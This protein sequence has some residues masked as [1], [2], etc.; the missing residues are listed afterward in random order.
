LN[1]LVEWSGDG[2]VL[3]FPGGIYYT[4]E[5]TGVSRDVRTDPGKPLVGAILRRLGSG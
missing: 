2:I 3:I 4:V 1:E 5:K